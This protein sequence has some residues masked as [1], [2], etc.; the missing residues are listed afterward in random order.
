MRINVIEIH[1]TNKQNLRW[2]VIFFNCMCE[3]LFSV[4]LSIHY[5]SWTR[6]ET[7]YEWYKC[8]MIRF[9]KWQSAD[10]IR[11]TRVR[12]TQMSNE[13][14]T[15]IVG[16]ISQLSTSSLKC[17]NHISHTN[18]NPCIRILQQLQVSNKLLTPKSKWDTVLNKEKA[19]HFQE[20]QG[21]TVVVQK[22]HTSC[23]SSQRLTVRSPSSIAGSTSPDD[24][25][26]LLFRDSDPTDK[27]SSNKRA[28]NAERPRTSSCNSI[29]C[30]ALA[31]HDVSCGVASNTTVVWSVSWKMSLSRLTN[32]YPLDPRE[33]LARS[34]CVD[35]RVRGMSRL[36]PPECDP[37]DIGSMTSAWTVAMQGRNQVVSKAT[38]ATSNIGIPSTTTSGR[39]P[40]CTIDVLKTRSLIITLEDPLTLPSQHTLSPTLLS[41]RT[42]R[43]GG[44]A[45]WLD[46]HI[47]NYES[48]K[49]GTETT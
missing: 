5:E 20:A 12:W 28:A 45:R 24:V 19:L 46:D 36:S 42:L 44:Q 10:A 47:D 22:A 43:D 17:R 1:M 49:E 31:P 48:L 23:S 8:Q 2:Y 21:L 26:S 39:R 7:W 34:C 16:V 40:S 18:T 11:S 41:Q 15:S 14:A 6:V 35:P 13:R 38:C 25:A 30:V 27:H 37:I 32:V 33:S 4:S 3:L 9:V 29:E